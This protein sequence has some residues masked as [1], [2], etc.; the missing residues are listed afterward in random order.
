MFMQQNIFHFCLHFLSSVC[1]YQLESGTSLKFS[2]CREDPVVGQ[3]QTIEPARSDT[4]VKD[5]NCT[6]A[7]EVTHV[8][9]AVPR[10]DNFPGILSNSAEAADAQK[11]VSSD[12]DAP[13]QR[14]YKKQ[15]PQANRTAYF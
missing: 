6:F 15:K 1:F 11:S 10:V 2:P 14:C 7:E 3:S 9:A 13:F 4:F 8:D 5:L 12:F